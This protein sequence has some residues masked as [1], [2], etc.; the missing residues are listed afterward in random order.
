MPHPRFRTALHRLPVAHCPLSR[1][2]GKKTLSLSLEHPETSGPLGRSSLDP[3]S[4]PLPCTSVFASPSASHKERGRSPSGGAALAHPPLR[5]SS[6]IPSKPQ[7]LTLLSHLSPECFG[8]EVW[9]GGNPLLTLC[10]PGDDLT[11][12]QRNPLL[13]RLAISGQA[14]DGTFVSRVAV[15]LCPCPRGLLRSSVPGTHLAHGVR[16]VGAQRLRGRP[17]AAESERPKLGG[18][19]RARRGICL[20]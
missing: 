2:A 16:R 9:G 7:L 4:A 10:S 12:H 5:A 6:W 1:R 18:A 8:A 14:A 13:A 15:R 20:R 3:T 19:G 11:G 17:A